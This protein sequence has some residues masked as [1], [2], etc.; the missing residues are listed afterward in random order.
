VVVRPEEWA[1]V[2]RSGQNEIARETDPVKALRLALAAMAA[3]ASR[4][5][6]EKQ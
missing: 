5:G 1:K 2:L 4:I 6:R 3:E